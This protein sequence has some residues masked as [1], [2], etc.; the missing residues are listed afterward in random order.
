MVKSWQPQWRQ[1]QLRFAWSDGSEMASFA[2]DKKVEIPEQMEVDRIYTMTFLESCGKGVKDTKKAGVNN[3]QDIRIH[4][5]IQWSLCKARWPT[6]VEL[7]SS[8]ISAG[9]EHEGG[10][11]FDIVGYVLEQEERDPTAT[12][13]KCKVVVVAVSDF[14][15]NTIPPE[16]LGRCAT[17]ACTVSACIAAKGVTLSEW[18]DERKV[19]TKHLSWVVFEPTS[20]IVFRPTRLS[21]ESPS[22]MKKCLPMVSVE[23]ISVEMLQK[24]MEQMREEYVRFK[25]SEM[26]AKCPTEKCCGVEISFA[27]VAT[28]LFER[29]VVLK[30]CPPMLLLVGSMSDKTGSLSPVKIWTTALCVLLKCTP[31]ACVA[32]WKKMGDDDEKESLVTDLNIAFESQ[33]AC[34]VGITLREK[35][36]GIVEPQVN[37]YNCVARVVSTQ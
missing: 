35:N 7:H 14:C 20:S 33:W 11:V 1:V 23:S 24:E 3:A 27:S 37:V 31:S 18:K 10:D 25:A 8:E 21:I 19:S 26:E 4:K 13:Q 36:N 28:S 6:K 32:R 12:I 17:V 29:N 16:L 15:L 9:Q 2:S 5:P 30:T 22:L 34:S